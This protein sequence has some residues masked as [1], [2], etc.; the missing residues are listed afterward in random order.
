VHSLCWNNRLRNC[1]LGR[2]QCK[3]LVR[4]PTFTCDFPLV[5]LRCTKARCA[6]RSKTALTARMRDPCGSAVFCINI[7]TFSLQ[8]NDHTN[9]E[10]SV[11]MR[12]FHAVKQVSNKCKVFEQ[13][14]IGVISDFRREVDEICALLGCDA[15]SSG[16]FLPTFRDNLSVPVSRVNPWSWDRQV[17][18]E[19]SVRNFHCSLRN[20]SEYSSSL[21]ATF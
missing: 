4:T 7:V 5:C 15:A 9:S 6:T 18:F 16:N 11:C 2:R 13:R 17:F 12:H 20:N 19:T 3:P 21:H 1:E 14:V 10:E 8:R